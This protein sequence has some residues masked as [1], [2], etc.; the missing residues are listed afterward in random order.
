M[1]PENQTENPP[2]PPVPSLAAPVVTGSVTTRLL[3]QPPGMISVI[4]P[5]GLT[6]YAIEVQPTDTRAGPRRGRNP[7]TGANVIVL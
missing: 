3:E 1:S 6:P 5:M 2:A 7:R 4:C